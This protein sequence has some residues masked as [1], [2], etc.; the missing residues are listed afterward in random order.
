M[1]DYRSATRIT[2]DREKKK[3]TDYYYY[4]YHFGDKRD[5][6]EAGG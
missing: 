5:G 3:E 6:E 4:H 1:T 2:R